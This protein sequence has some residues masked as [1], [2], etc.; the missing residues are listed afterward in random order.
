MPVA[1]YIITHLYSHAPP[2]DEVFFTKS[3]LPCWLPNSQLGERPV[4]LEQCSKPK[5]PTDKGGCD[6]FPF[7]SSP[8]EEKNN[9]SY[10]Y[11]CSLGSV[12]DQEKARGEQQT[13]LPINW[14]WQVFPWGIRL[15]VPWMH[16]FIRLL[17]SSDQA[18]KAVANCCF[19]IALKSKDQCRQP[20]SVYL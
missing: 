7:P 20:M 9:A 17:I 13:W 1:H 3:D 6:A 5:N 8:L 15:A 14:T 18:G 10:H 2:P 12:L 11:K 19:S 16:W 4:E